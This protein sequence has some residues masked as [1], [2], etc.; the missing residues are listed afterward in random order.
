MD[1]LRSLD[2]LY[3]TKPSQIMI[4]YTD[5]P[6]SKGVYFRAKQY[7]LVEQYQSA[8][9][10]LLETQTEE[11]QHWFETENPDNQE[12]FEIWH[13]IRLFEAALL[14]YNIVVDLSW[15]LCYVCAEYAL[16]I[17]G[18]VIDLDKMMNI[19]EA[20]N[21]FRKAEKEL[22]DP[23]NQL[24]YLKKTSPQYSDVIDHIINFLSN[25]L[26]SETRE[27]Y[28]YIKHRGKPQYEELE[29]HLGPKLMG[30]YVNDVKYPAA[31]RDVQ[32][33]INLKKVIESLYDFDNHELFPYIKG[34]FIK[35]EVIVKPSPLIDL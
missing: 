28:N 15:M 12:Y 18:N 3:P 17:D 35:L 32:K 33:P 24:E 11:W 9:V 19:E 1:F 22:K 27:L 16:Y 7:E 6:N 10:F 5:M 20:Y 14:F 8:R 29:K 13:S 34:L 25:F 21:T 30:F 2:D 4:N 23:K 26:Q 31:S